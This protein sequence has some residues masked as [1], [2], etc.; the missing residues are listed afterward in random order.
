MRRSAIGAARWMQRRGLSEGEVARALGV[1]RT[2]LHSWMDGWQAV[3]R[4][5]C[6]RGRP[7]HRASPLQ[8]TQALAVL[9]REGPTTSILQL[10]ESAPEVARR[11]L[12]ELRARVARVCRR[13]NQDSFLELTWL[14][15]GAVWAGDF[16]H[17]PCLIDAEY[18]RIVLLRD[19]ASQ[20]QILAE[21]SRTESA[22]EASFALEAAIAEHGAPLVIKYDN[23]VGFIARRTRAILEREGVEVLY[24]PVRRPQYN[25]SCEAG[26]GSIKMRARRLAGTA[27][28][29][30]A[31]TCDDL[32]EARLEANAAPAPRSQELSREALWQ[33]RPPISADERASFQ[34]AV[35]GELERLRAAAGELPKLSAWRE[36]L[37]AATMQRRALV[38]ALIQRGYLVIR[39]G[40]VCPL[41]R[42]R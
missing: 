31:W 25:G 9:S 28:R 2:T 30:G 5:V 7:P 35:R 26:G 34:S 14:R 23:G 20:Q 29:P 3:D 40:R 16:S 1:A 17:A 32:E 18:G 33:A 27:G 22:D 42:R 41:N 36:H 4:E 38:R 6:A 21:A 10:L 11:E 13:R 24:S 37:R 15:P 8:R 19:L 39:R 12:E